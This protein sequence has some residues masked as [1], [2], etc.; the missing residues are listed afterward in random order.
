MKKIISLL[1]LVTLLF[2]FTGCSNKTEGYTIAVPNDATNEARALLLLQDLGIITLKDGAD[3]T[4]TINDIAENPYNVTFKE[5]EAAQL[6]N[7]LQDVDYAVINSN[8]A[9]S[10]GLNPVN[11]SLA[12]EG[13][14]SYYANV[15]V[16][17]E[18]NENNPLVLAL[19]AALRSEQVATYI[20]ATYGGSV[21]STVEELT[22]GYDSSIDYNALNGQ[23]ISVACSPTPHAEILSV[24]KDILS[25]KGITL[26]IQEYTDYIVPNTVVEDN[27]VTANYFQHL[28]YLT[29]FNEKNGT[30]LVSIGA[31]H[32]EPMG[33]YGGKQNSLD[34]LYDSNK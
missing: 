21:V 19:L 18:G 1:L 22:D 30:H 20:S 11:D 16:V 24:A 8:Y 10:A 14:S 29:D 2:T 4:A 34:A 26:D 23:T 3:I 5:I 12:I 25:A 6:P 15:L 9:I 13:E 7:Y 31:I 32:V 28:P 33:I 17:K 27:T